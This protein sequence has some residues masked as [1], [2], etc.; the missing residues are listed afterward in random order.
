[1]ATLTS[2]VNHFAKPKEG[3]ITTLSSTIGVAAATVPLTSTS[4]LTNGDIFVGII[5]PTTSAKQAFTGTVDTAGSQITSVVWTEGTNVGHTVGATVV[6]YVAATTV[7]MISKG[8]LV[9]HAQAGTHTAALITSRTEDTSPDVGADFLLTYDTSATSLKKVKPTSLGLATGWTAGQLPAVSS[10]TENGNRSADITFASTVASLLTPGMRIRTSRTVAAPT[11]M[12][13]AFNGTNHYF[14]KVTPTSTLSTVT[15]NFT[16]MGWA[17]PTAYGSAGIACRVDAA[18]NNGIY[19]FMTSTGQ[20]Q[21]Q[22][23]NA[24]VANF[25]NASTYQS[26]P[27]NKKTHVAASWATGT[28]V[29]YFDGVVVPSV[30]TSGGTAPNTA[31]TGGD[32][33]IGRFGAQN[34]GYF[35]GYISGVGVFNAVLSAATIRSYKNQVLSGSETNCI[36]AWSLNNTGVNQ[37][38]AGTNDLTATNSV[39][40]TSGR[41]PYCTDANGVAAG[42]YDWAIVTKVATTVATVQYPE[43]CAIPTSGGISTVDYSGVKAP[44]GMPVEKGRWSVVLHQ[45]ASNV[46][47]AVTTGTA[48]NPGG[49]NINAPVGKWLSTGNFYTVFTGSTTADKSIIVSLSTSASAADNV[50]ANSLFLS[51][52]TL[53][54]LTMALPSNVEIN[55]TTATPYYTVFIGAGGGVLTNLGFGTTASSLVTLEFAYL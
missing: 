53:F 39:G 20:V 5:D 35:T 14:T 30:T 10:V 25:K 42:T 31:G 15:D 37:Q 34:S 41:S 24:G 26:L 33:S 13:G 6:D 50:N 9:E 11:Y 4:G 8:I 27:L 23:N 43:G 3:F 16:I 45:R 22:I 21:L 2:V 40:Y 52:Q 44:F 29:L 17:E 54:A 28:C 7:G 55:V 32:F 19:L 48:Y 51:A 12:G 47:A 38:A 36:G 49:L 46:Q 1:M 18:G